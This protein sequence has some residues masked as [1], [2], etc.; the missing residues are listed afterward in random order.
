MCDFDRE[1]DMKIDIVCFA[2]GSGL[3][4]YAISLAKALDAGGHDVRVVT[5]TTM[6]PDVATLHP[7]ISTPFRRTRT[8]PIDYFRM[9]LTVLRRRPDAV[10]LQSWKAPI[11]DAFFM[12]IFHLAGIVCLCTV[13]DIVPHQPHFWSAVDIPIFFKAFDGLVAHS[14]EAKARLRKIGYK[15]EIAVIPHGAY[16]IFDT[17]HLTSAQARQMF[18]DLNPSDFVVLFF[19][20]LDERKGILEFITAAERLRDLPNVKFVIAGSRVPSAVAHQLDAIRASEGNLQIFEGFVPFAQ[21]QRYFA[22]ADL[23]VTPYREGSTSGVLKLAIAFKRPVLSTD[24]GDARETIASKHG[25]I[26]RIIPGIDV[27][28]ELCAEIKSMLK[29][30]PDYSMALEAVR[31]EISW[32]RIGQQYSEFAMALASASRKHGTPMPE[33][34]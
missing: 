15:G 34:R 28:G 29:E 19:G 32:D 16:D 9:C 10:I 17:L 12:R 18:R 6:P 11:V 2:G 24:V 4:H 20:H 27:V 33:I 8:L 1:D 22:A 7:K 31:A 3:G 30:Q 25:P 13:H 5:S 26:G 21:V 14:S 23:V